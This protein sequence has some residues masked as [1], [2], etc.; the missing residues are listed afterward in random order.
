MKQILLLNPEEATEEEVKTYSV[1]EAA[2]AVVFDEDNNVAILHVKNEGYYKLPG[3]G[4]DGEDKIVGLERECQEEI[5]CDVDVISEIGMIVEYRKFCNLKQISHCY[6]A[7]IR[8]EK[9]KPN[10]TEEELKDGFEQLWLPYDEVK[11]LV[12]KTTD[13]TNFEGSAYIIPRDS[14]ILNEVSRFI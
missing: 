6:L 7:K 12:A 2:R 9:G 3:G 13:K 4:L 10:F 11:K 1:R 14:A 5:G 8:G